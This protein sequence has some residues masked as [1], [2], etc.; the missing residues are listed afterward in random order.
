MLVDMSLGLAVPLALA[1]AGCFA[2]GIAVQHQEAQATS[3]ADLNHAQLIGVLV[4]RPLWLLSNVA[5]V[6][7]AALQTAALA[8]GSLV[9]VQPILVMGLLFAMPISARLHRRRVTARQ[10]TWAVVTVGGLAAFLALVGE[11]Q[12]RSRPHLDHS[13]VTLGCMAIVGLTAAGAALWPGP[14]AKAALY[15]V[16][17]GAAAGLAAAALKACTGLLRDHGVG[18]LASP[19]PYAAAVTGILALVLSQAAYRTGPLSA[20]VPALTLSDPVVSVAV[21][22]SLFAERLAGH[23]ARHTLAALV[24]VI[25]FGAVVALARADDGPG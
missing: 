15:G 8:V 25:A 7:G 4:Q 5:L 1:S 12:G 18:V 16:S 20:S 10:W 11:A 9:V 6:I 23:G 13:G 19:Y 14:R 22:I 3:R 17:S 21:G 2:A 24:L